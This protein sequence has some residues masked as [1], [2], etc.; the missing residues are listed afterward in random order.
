[1]NQPIKLSRGEVVGI[2]K[3]KIPRAEDFKY[4]IPMLSFIVIEEP[5]GGFVSSCLHFHIDGYGSA[6][7]VAV[8]DMIDSIKDFLKSNFSELQPD[9]AWRNLMELNHIRIDKGKV[10][11]DT[12][13]LWDAY[14]D[15]QF[16]L[17]AQGV[18]TDSAE[19]LRKRMDQLK[20][21]ID[22]LEYENKK[23][24]GL[25][26]TRPTFIPSPIIDYTSIRRAA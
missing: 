6:D 12:A 5:E 18:S 17:A 25:T 1:M 16:M 7:R 13:E 8:D 2:G 21:R 10:N 3:V 9:D 24:K 19:S 14:R 15:V 11:E 20:Q 22:W 23:L 26:P 4:E